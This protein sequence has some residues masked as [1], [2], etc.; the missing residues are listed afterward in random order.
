[1]D[2][3]ADW[4]LTCKANKLL[5]LDT[6]MVVDMLKMPHTV[7]MKADWTNRDQAIADYLKTFGR[8]G[9]PFNVVY[10]PGA[11]KGITLPELLSEDKLRKA[12]EKARGGAAAKDEQRPSEL[13]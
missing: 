13:P 3:T 7:A 12:L 6:A 9:I 5:V 8:Y 10:G 1:M 11:P 4:C 2:V